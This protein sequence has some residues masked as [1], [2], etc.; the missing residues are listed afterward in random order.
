M[1]KYIA[2]ENDKEPIIQVT[3][4][5]EKQKPKMLYTVYRPIKTCK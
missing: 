1:E 5:N 4:Q 2:I 3:M